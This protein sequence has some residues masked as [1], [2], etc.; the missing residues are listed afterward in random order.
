MESG[1]VKN[2]EVSNGRGYRESEIK[3]QRSDIRMRGEEITTE[4]A[5]VSRGSGGG[6]IE[7]DRQR[8]AEV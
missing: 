4:V 6:R 8:K 3:D 5:E 7:S 2:R 1:M